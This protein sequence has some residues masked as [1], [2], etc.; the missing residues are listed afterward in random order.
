MRPP[1]HEGNRPP[2]ARLARI[3]FA[4]SPPRPDRNGLR[5]RPPAARQRSDL[6]RTAV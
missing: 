4:V 5:S 1:P 6:R 3:A 2:Q